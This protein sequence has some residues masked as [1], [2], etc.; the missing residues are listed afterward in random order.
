VSWQVEGASERGRDEGHVRAEEIGKRLDGWAMA[1]GVMGV[2]D[3]RGRF[4]SIAEIAVQ[5]ELREWWWGSG[6]G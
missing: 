1:R 4:L 2:L 5:K 6:R 3:E